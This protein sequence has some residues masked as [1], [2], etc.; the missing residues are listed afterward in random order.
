MTINWSTRSRPLTSTVTAA[1]LLMILLGCG[2][3]PAPEAKPAP[4]PSNKQLGVTVSSPTQPGWTLVKSNERETRF[5]RASAV[6]TAVASSRTL[7]A[8]MFGEGDDLLA[9]LE[10][11]KQSQLASTGLKL[12]SLHFYRVRFKGLTC[13]QYDGIFEGVSESKS[14]FTHFNFKGYLCPLHDTEQSVVELEV[15]NRTNQ[16]GFSDELIRSSGEFFEAA[17]F[18]PAK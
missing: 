18:T 16:R 17:V 10:V 2:R 1:G 7:M 11:W 6:D 8:T 9:R 14:Q 13:L 15:S 12:D 3:E 4:L 5:E